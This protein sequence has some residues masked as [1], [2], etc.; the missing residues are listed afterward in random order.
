MNKLCSI[1]TGD[2]SFGN[3]KKLGRKEGQ[4]EGNHHNDSYKVLEF[5]RG[6]WNL[7]LISHLNL[8]IMFYLI[9]L[10]ANTKRTDDIS[11]NGDPPKILSSLKELRILSKCQNQLFWMF[12]TNS[13]SYHFFVLVI[14]HYKSLI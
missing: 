1:L 12:I 14:S 6:Y 10:E 8:S 4:G 13:E 3:K 11:K 5:Y 9:N 2:K 7:G